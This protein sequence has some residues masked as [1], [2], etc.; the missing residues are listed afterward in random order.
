VVSEVVVVDDAP[1]LVRLVVVGARKSSDEPGRTKPHSDPGD[2]IHTAR[3]KPGYSTIRLTMYETTKLSQG[4][5]SI[6]FTKTTELTERCS[7]EVMQPISKLAARCVFAF[8][9]ACMKATHMLSG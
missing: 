7:Q 6:C 3:D 9:A 4:T 2:A 8:A 5:D 1:P